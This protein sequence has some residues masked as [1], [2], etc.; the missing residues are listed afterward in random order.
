[1]VCLSLSYLEELYK[2][3]SIRKKKLVLLPYSKS[4]F[5]SHQGVLNYL[6]FW[7]SICD[8]FTKRIAESAKQKSVNRKFISVFQNE[9]PS[10]E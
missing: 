5:K 4:N 2:T 8:L 7:K 1:M 3:S 10:D 6:L 9:A